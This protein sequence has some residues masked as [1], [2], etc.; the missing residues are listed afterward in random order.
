MESTLPFLQFQTQRFILHISISEQAHSP[1][2]DVTAWSLIPLFD[3]RFLPLD[4]VHQDIS[5]LV[6][7]ASVC[8][9]GFDDMDLL[10][11]SGPQ[12]LHPETDIVSKYKI[13]FQ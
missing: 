4:T 10:Q 11:W 1:T 7:L 9:V 8:C 3:K 6:G 12:L 13:Y 2:D 5:Y